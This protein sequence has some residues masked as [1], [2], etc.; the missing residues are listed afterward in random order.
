MQ[1]GYFGSMRV[2]FSMSGNL[3]VLCNPRVELVRG[4]REQS[5]LDR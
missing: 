5:P 3:V 1:A 2:Q 4:L